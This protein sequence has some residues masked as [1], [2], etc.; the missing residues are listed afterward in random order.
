MKYSKKFPPGT[1]TQNWVLYTEKQK[2]LEKPV[3]RRWVT[4]PDGRKV[5]ERFPVKHYSA[6]AH[7]P[8]EL[9]KLVIRLNGAIPEEQ[10]LRKKLEIRHAYI[11][12]QMLDKY[13]DVILARVPNRENANREFS[14]LKR[15]FLNFFIHKFGHESPLQWHLNQEVWAWAL[16]NSFPEDRKTEAARYQIWE[17]ATRVP[18]PKVIR[19]IVQAANR[20]MAFLHQRRPLDALPLV[21]SPVSKA[22]FKMIAAT[23]KRLKLEENGVYIPDADWELIRKNLP[24][25]LAP[26][27]RL[28]YDYGLRRAE[29]LALRPECLMEDHYACTQQL[30]GID[31]SEIA[32][33]SPRGTPRYSNL[34]GRLERKIPYWFADPNDTYDLIQK[35]FDEKSLVHPDTLSDRWLAFMKSLNLNYG[36]HDIRHTWITRAVMKHPVAEVMLA[37]G[38][39]NIET[40]MRYFHDSRQL[41]Q[42]RFVPRAKSA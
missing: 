32:E 3:I 34:K 25:E 8:V 4:F 19:E 17:D 24:S 7:N 36:F 35:A 21:F 1:K 30:D 39:E 6:I 15:Y 14:Y 16:M 20:F 26:Y 42:K 37:A 27:A 9:E 41:S 10:K 2:G 13:R 5:N 31:K 11:D 22:Q 38:H 40:T 28:A 12:D 18:S 33:G 29:T 23:R